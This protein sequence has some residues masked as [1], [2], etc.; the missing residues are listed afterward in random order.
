MTEKCPVC[1]QALVMPRGPKKARAAILSEKPGK[2]EL[3]ELR[4]FCGGAGRVLRV[5]LAR[6]GLD[7]IS[8]YI[9]NLWMHKPKEE[10]YEWHLKQ[11]IDVCKGRKFVLLMGSDVVEAYC[12]TNVMSV[13]GLEV[14]SHLLS[15][16]KIFAAPNP[17]TA[18]HGP[19]GE[20][21]FAIEQFAK[22]MKEDQL[23][24]ELGYD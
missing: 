22:A 10:C 5:E 9:S 14:K 21:R 15:G 8:F 18:F 3:K 2:D 16:P 6:Q 20:L 23:I 17:A 12:E 1:K 24:Q 7:L 11:S 13:S 19:I 4:P